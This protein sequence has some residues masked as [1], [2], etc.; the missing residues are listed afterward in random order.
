MT[1]IAN[2]KRAYEVDKADKFI[3]FLTLFKMKKPGWIAHLALFHYTFVQLEYH[4]AN[5]IR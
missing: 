2:W 1:K 3:R 5:L 4:L